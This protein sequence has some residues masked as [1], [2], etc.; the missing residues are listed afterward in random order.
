MPELKKK[1]IANFSKYKVINQLERNF[2]KDFL[3]YVNKNLELIKK[4]L[5]KIKMLL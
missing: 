5:N 4:Q 1:K 2:H 3:L